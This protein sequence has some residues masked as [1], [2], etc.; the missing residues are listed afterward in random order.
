MFCSASCGPDRGHE[1]FQRG[2]EARWSRDRDPV[3]DCHQV[4]SHGAAARVAG[5]AQAGGIDLGPARQIVEGTQAVPDPVAG[6]LSPDQQG[7]D[8][9]HG[10][11]GRAADHGLAA[12]IEP[13]KP[14]TLADRVVAHHGH[15][16]FRQQD[17]G[18][19]IPLISLTVV[20][21]AAR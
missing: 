4:R 19:L 16:V 2:D 14:L 8:P 9:R 5:T 13:L 6:Q 18:A 7:T 21:V 11:F 1:T 3:V 10:V 15:A 20:A 12:G 17:A